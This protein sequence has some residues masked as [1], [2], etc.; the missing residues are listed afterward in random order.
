MDHLHLSFLSILS[1][2]MCLF[3]RKFN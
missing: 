3:L 1:L 2:S